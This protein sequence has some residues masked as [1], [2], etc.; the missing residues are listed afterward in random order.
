M[1]VGAERRVH[2]RFEVPCRV[3]IDRQDGQ[4]LRTRTL[5]VSNGGAFFIASAVPRIGETF[6]VRLS[7]PRETSNTFF[8]EQFAV[9]AEVVRHEPRPELGEATGV[10]VKFE[11]TLS[12]DLP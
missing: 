9:K 11:R 5:N 7:V 10:A 3:R 2:A 8:L 4:P 6:H 1:A 12:L